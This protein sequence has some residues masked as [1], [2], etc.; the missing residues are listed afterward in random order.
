MREFI[1][2]SRFGRTAPDFR[3]LHDAGRLDIVYDCA[4]ASLFMSHAIRKDTIFHAILNGPPKPPLHLQINGPT[5]HDV[6]VD[7]E[8][9]TQILRRQLES[10]NHPGIT[11]TKDNY[12][13]L[14]K[15]KADKKDIFVLEEGGTDVSQANVSENSIFVLGDHVGLP[16]IVERFT[17][18]YGSKVSLGKKAYLASSCITILNYLVD[19]KASS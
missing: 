14:I 13:N 3:N 7:Q 9:W 6:R 11:L 12:E 18:R 10:K 19:R 1:V 4:V 16:K 5:L 17:L 8:T 15:T 2:Y